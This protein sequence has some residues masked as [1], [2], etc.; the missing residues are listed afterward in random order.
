MPLHPKIIR[1]RDVCDAWCR[2]Q[3]MYD[4]VLPL[5][6]LLGVFFF[7]GYYL[8]LSAPQNFPPASLLNIKEGS[9]VAEVAQLLKEKG[10]IRSELVFEAAARAWGDGTGVIA[11]EYFFPGD[12]GVLTVA[13]RLTAGDH[14][15]KSV[16]V[17]VPEGAS[18]KEIA[19][20][21]VQKV[22]DFDSQEFLKLAAPKEGTLFPDT[23]FFLPGEDP[24]L[25][26][27]AMERDFK[28]HFDAPAV[29]A[30]VAQFGK[31]VPDVLTM[32]SIIEK[33]AATTQDRRVIAGILWHRIALNMPLQVDAVFPYIIGVNSLQLTRT[34]LA[35]TSPYNTYTHK[36][37]P[38]GPISNPSMDSIMAAVTPVKTNYLYYL[39]D[40]NGT[41]HYCVTYG[42]QQANAAR[43]LGS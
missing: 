23:Y 6:F 18:S 43:Y 25:V 12:E 24:E 34:D 7:L 4:R 19:A 22:A 10:Y 38:P 27:T 2:Q 15:L 8:T 9:S 37:L 5:S 3:R 35:T 36:G 41:M 26:L 42:C 30:A 11:G 17:T 20:E 1:A 29:S 31:P 28:N 13:M 16:R 14:E 40:K 39:S 21:L 33:E 32:S